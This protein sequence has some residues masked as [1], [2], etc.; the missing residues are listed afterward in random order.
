MLICN[1]I[2]GDIKLQSHFGPSERRSTGSDDTQAT[3]RK[4]IQHLMKD[5]NLLDI[6]RH[7]NP[8]MLEGCEVYER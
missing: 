3:S 6:W 5:L 1:F 2:A 7:L 4:L 8:D